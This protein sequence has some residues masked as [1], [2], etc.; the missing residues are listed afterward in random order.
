MRLQLVIV[1]SNNKVLTTS[2]NNTKMLR[3]PLKKSNTVLRQVTLPTFNRALTQQTPA[4]LHSQP[5]FGFLTSASLQ[6]NGVASFNGLS[7]IG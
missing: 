3:Q 6:R 1:Y 2:Y 7:S 4:A 5:V